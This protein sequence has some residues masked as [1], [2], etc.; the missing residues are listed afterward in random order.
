MTR[1][2]LALLLLAISL[3][4]CTAA[5]KRTSPPAAPAASAPSQAAAPESPSPDRRLNECI[6]AKD[7][8]GLKRVIAQGVPLDAFDDEN[9]SALARAAGLGD[10]QACTILLEAGA[11]PKAPTTSYGTTPMHFVG[12]PAVIDL[13]IQHGVDINAIDSNN[14]T[15][16]YYNAKSGNIEVVKH[17]LARGA[18]PCHLLVNRTIPVFFDE[19]V[20]HERD[21]T[22]AQRA[23]FPEISRILHEAA[24]KNGCE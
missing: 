20:E 9:E 2:D 17:L 10:I 1:S 13:L 19:V 12:S 7:Y 18:D 22:D 4:P 16:L 8:E 6:E 5:C 14:M 24:A 3:L 23:A 11:S 15:P 21:L